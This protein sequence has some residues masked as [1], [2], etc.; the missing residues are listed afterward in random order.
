[1]PAGPR[2][3]A[4]RS[5]PIAGPRPIPALCFALGLLWPVAHAAAQDGARDPSQPFPVFQTGGHSGVVRSIVFAGPQELL[6]GGL[7]KVLNAWD[8]DRPGELRL[9]RTTRLPAWKGPRGSVY[10]MALS[11]PARGP[12]ILA[13]AGQGTSA[14]GGEILLFTYPETGPGQDRSPTFVGM[15]GMSGLD[16]NMKP[17]PPGRDGHDGVVSALAF[18][19]GT[20]RLISAGEDGIL[21]LWDLD[22]LADRKLVATA[23]IRDGQP[24]DPNRH[25]LNALALTPDGRRVVTGGVDST[26]RVWDAET[27]RRL[28]EPLTLPAPGLA[29]GLANSGDDINSL[30][31]SPDGRWIVA[32][33][34]D[35]ELFRVDLEAFRDPQPLPEVKNDGSAAVDVVRISPDRNAPVLAVGVVENGL[36]LDGR[37]RRPSMASW[38]ELRSLPD[39]KVLH[40]FP[41][42]DN[43]IRACEFS[44]DGRRL[45]YS[46]G[47][48]RA[49]HVV[50]LDPK[51]LPLP[52]AAE[53][54]G[55]GRGRSIWDVRFA[56]GAG[57]NLR[58]A[59]TRTR[60]DDLAGRPASYDLFEP[61]ENRPG[62]ISAAELDF[63][64]P[65]P[66][67]EVVGDDRAADTLHLRSGGERKATILL[68]AP[69]D[70]R[71][72][73]KL[74]L[75]LKDEF[76]WPLVAVAMENGV[77]IFGI[78]PAPPAHPD[79][80][81][82]AP[83]L[84]RMIRKL[85]GHSG[86][87]YAL[88]VSPDRRWLLTGGADQTVRLYATEGLGKVPPLGA[89]LEKVEGQ[90]WP[91][92]AGVTP[93]GFASQAGLEPGDQIRGV[94]VA[95]KPLAGL[96]DSTP[97]DASLADLP[98]NIVV[99]RPD[100]K[101]GAPEVK[102]ISIRKNQNPVV[103]LLAL[104]PTSAGSKGPMGSADYVL[105]MPSGYY[106]TSI[107]GDAKYLGWHQNRPTEA[108]PFLFN[109]PPVEFLPAG[110]FEARFHRKDVIDRVLLS[111]GDLTKLVAP[112]PKPAAPVVA[113]PSV[114]KQLVAR[115]KLADVEWPQVP[116]PTMRLTFERPAGIPGALRYRIR[117]K[118]A[119]A[120][121]GGVELTFPKESQ[122]GDKLL[123]PPIPYP[124]GARPSR[125]WLDIEAIEPEAH[126][127]EP[128]SIVVPAAPAPAPTLAG[129]EPPAAP[130]EPSVHILSV[131]ASGPKP[132]FA[133][134]GATYGAQN[135]AE[136][137][138][139][140]HRGASEDVGLRYRL[141]DARRKLFTS[142]EGSEPVA[143]LAAHLKTLVDRARD[144]Y[145]RRHPS[146]LVVLYLEAPV[147]ETPDPA[148][149]SRILL[150]PRPRSAAA[151][152]DDISLSA[153]EFAAPL[154][155]LADQYGWQVVV[156]LDGYHP[157]ADEMR[158]G[159][160]KPW[161]P[162]VDH[163]TRLLVKGNVTVVNASEQAPSRRVPRDTGHGAMGQAWIDALDPARA[164]EGRISL[165]LGV[166]TLDDY[167]EAHEAAFDPFRRADGTLEVD[168]ITW[169]P[170]RRTFGN[171]SLFTP[172]APASSGRLAN[173]RVGNQKAN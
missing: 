141:D 2:R 156:F 86:S 106:L 97:L 145:T 166:S 53:A 153:S 41:R 137:A 96:D 61:L 140:F 158:S 7:D 32:G 46:G 36:P 101:G 168:P 98:I 162:G 103:S 124:R 113:T 84:Y 99:E 64:L 55:V 146:D 147:L 132:H 92:V 28:L 130:P 87:V 15:L 109:A 171:D 25:I 65:E 68:N 78:D 154:V 120:P 126:A 48:D 157:F 22:D 100:P 94:Q 59:F 40:R 155:E 127:M 8:L 93:F 85:V 136:A 43:V 72:W 63:D 16:A 83:P 9:R 107:R 70:K 139:G 117:P 13:V 19:P 167:R 160:F 161:R 144:G 74:A 129:V 89:T 69:S 123:S 62:R 56:K 90:P 159:T 5:R 119:G 88:A 142:P 115:P 128:L 49:I 79:R 121:A 37:A 173:A 169:N 118:V 133:I 20:N 33:R 34:E 11:N 151:R 29:G 12:R 26:L 47:D 58:L 50:P 17:A 81:E 35:G 44:P 112:G 45:A 116:L 125:V 66:G 111:G 76:G 4:A 31:I 138:A 150:K 30:D 21:R 52:A 27:G 148:Q 102:R 3:N 57:N 38:V 152:L 54:V 71:W 18:R 60:A 51:G 149:G 67:F 75:P 131:A 42:L 10:A 14:Q 134:R 39:G 170:G 77:G 91:R 6:S 1:M 108:N 163:L 24:H 95:G 105:W 122:P 172:P 165:R 82:L 73:S 104:P 135:W 143:L 114:P 110:A 80:P 23:S 164:A